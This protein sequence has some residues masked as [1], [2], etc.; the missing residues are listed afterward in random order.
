MT[1]PL[2]DKLH[3]RTHLSVQVLHVRS[4]AVQVRLDQRAG[5]DRSI[6]R[7]PS[8]FGRRTKGDI[9]L[10]QL[11]Y[12]P[13]VIPG[14]PLEARLLLLEFRGVLTGDLLADR[15]EPRLMLLVLIGL[16]PA[17]RSSVFLTRTFCRATSSSCLVIA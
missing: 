3:C 1:V 11:A 9:Q 17:R 13:I 8:A 4:Q 6:A 14:P 7:L 5:L 10:L 12:G 16:F 15:F 2:L